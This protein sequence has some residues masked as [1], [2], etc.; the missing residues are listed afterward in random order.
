MPRA[1]EVPS[2]ALI[3]QEYFCQRLIAQRDASRATVA[4]YRDTFRLLL[5]YARDRIQRMPTDLVLADIDAPLVLAFLEHLERD[6]GN[7]PRTRNAR[8]AAIRSFLQF[9]AVS[10]PTSLPSIQRVL[11]ILAKRFDR[12]VLG[13]LTREEVARSSR[14]QTARHGRGDAIT[15]CSRRSTIEK[16]TSRRSRTHASLTSP[17]IAVAASAFRVRG[18]RRGLFPYGRARAVSS[19]RGYARRSPPPTL[20]FYLHV[21]ASGSLGLASTTVSRVPWR[22]P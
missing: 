19:R 4:S 5:G 7:S 10:C 1:R 2:F 16:R 8:L 18:E 22:A 12:R 17:P 20:R 21:R 15:R 3:L 13:F 11:A 14:R 6:R 9:A